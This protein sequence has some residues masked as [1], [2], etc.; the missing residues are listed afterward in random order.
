MM[1]DVNSLIPWSNWL[2]PA[3]Y[4]KRYDTVFF[5]VP[6]QE[7]SAVEFCQKEMQGAV[8]DLPSKFIAKCCNEEKLACPPPQFYELA[9][10][11]LIN[12]NDPEQLERM[13]NAFKICPQ[14]A[15]NSDEPQI[16]TALLPG[17]H[18]FEWKHRWEGMD[19]RTFTK[20][21]LRLDTNMPIHRM[22]FNE[23]PMYTNVELHI[24]NME[25]M[26]TKPHLFTWRE[27]MDEQRKRILNEILYR[28]RH[29]E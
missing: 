1:L 4:P 6:L 25:E 14:I 13:T 21:E 9:R 29:R 15:L 20:D 26:E 11:R 8:W 18:L 17:D 27:T 10:L 2:T 28:P 16:R 5:V 7:T 23:N 22:T 3:S 24:S 12:S 19:L